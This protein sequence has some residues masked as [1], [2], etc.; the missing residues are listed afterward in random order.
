[1]N[2]C[3]DGPEADLL[4]ALD[5]EHTK[6]ISRVISPRRRSHPDSPCRVVSRASNRQSPWLAVFSSRTYESFGV[7][8]HS[9]LQSRP[10][11]VRLLMTSI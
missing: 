5:C 10:S 11:A 4:K 1:M 2:Q 8:L 6:L 7:L 9:A 3:L